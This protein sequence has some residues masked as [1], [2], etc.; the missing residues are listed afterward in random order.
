M[1]K[2]EPQHAGVHLV[3]TLIS[4][5]VGEDEKRPG[6]D[7]QYIE[8]R[9]EYVYTVR[10]SM[11]SYSLEF[12]LMILSLRI[13]SKKQRSCQRSREGICKDFSK[14][15]ILS[16]FITWVNLKCLYTAYQI[17]LVSGENVNLN[18][19]DDTVKTFS[20]AESNSQKLDDEL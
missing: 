7:Q 6:T 19:T 9:H 16:I 11:S 8:K 3:L 5:T 20:T 2:A 13:S 1:C 10:L 17:Y 14:S 18:N 12:L 15:Y 4:M